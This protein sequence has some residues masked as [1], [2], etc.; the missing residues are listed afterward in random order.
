MFN[1]QIAAL[2]LAMGFPLPQPGFSFLFPVASLGFSAA[3][4]LKNYGVSQRQRGKEIRLVSLKEDEG[5]RPGGRKLLT[6]AGDPKGLRWIGVSLDPRYGT[7][8]F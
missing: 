5:S 7:G 8:Y 1:L 2:F 4:S 6:S 3:T